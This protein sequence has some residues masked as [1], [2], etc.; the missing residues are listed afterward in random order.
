MGLL[1][2]VTG[3][4]GAGKSVVARALAD[5]FNPSVLV[6]GD[7]FFAF[8]AS[9]RVDPWLPESQQQNEVVIRARISTEACLP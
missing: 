4:P 8:L 5:R 9:G 6:E 1:V 3:P 7:A 2:V